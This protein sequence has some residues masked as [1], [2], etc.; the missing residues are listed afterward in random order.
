MDVMTDAGKWDKVAGF[1]NDLRIPDWNE[2]LFL[3]T[4]EKLP[5]WG[6]D[7]QILDLGC[8]AGRYSIAVAEKCGHVTGSDISPCM[9]EFAK[10]KAKDHNKDNISFVT[11]CWRDI[12]IKKNGYEK[13]FD[14]V[15]GHMTPA[16]ESTEDIEKATDASKG[17]CALAT[18]AKRRTP[19]M[20]KLFEYLGR[21]PKKTDDDRITNIFSHL[22]KTGRYPVVNYYLRDD[23]QELEQ[24]DAVEFLKERCL[25]D[26]DFS[27]DCRTIE[28]ICEFVKNES[29]DGRFVNKAEAVIVTIVWK[30]D[31]S[32]SDFN[33]YKR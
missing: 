16:L 32:E 22:Y 1:F 26:G 13:K 4:I 7:S 20:Q 9:I 3:K 27:A 23:T 6:G 12:D 15:F 28:K 29:T 10:V 5:V 30:A 14:L 31:N 2:D 21:A 11:E 33:G 19:V 17:Y 24:N 25:L 8:G 18:F